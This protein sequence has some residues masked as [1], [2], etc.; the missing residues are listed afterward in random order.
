MKKYVVYTALFGDYDSLIEPDVR[1]SECDFICF[2]DQPNLVSN[3]WKIRVVNRSDIPPNLLNREYKVLP[4]KYLAQYNSSLYIDSNI[5]V[6]S[7]PTP[8]FESLNENEP[9]FIANHP[10]RKCVYE[11]LEACFKSGKITKEV[12]CLIVNK[13]LS[14]GVPENNG[15][16]ENNI[17]LRLHHNKKVIDL[18][19]SW[20]DLIFNFCSRDQISLPYLIWSMRI[21]ISP[22]SV[23]SKKPNRFFYFRPHKYAGDNFNL[24]KRFLF[25]ISMRRSDN[26]FY[27]VVA[28]SFDKI[29]N[30]KSKLK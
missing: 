11:E 6:K 29:Y 18:M 22:L 21:N 17:I 24:I 19:E 5:G 12:K 4:H 27:Y 20:H 26:Y 3:F 13:Y 15:L 9:I 14:E 2:T 1:N 30:F 8:L 7:D 25:N 23:S 28:K 16:T 10:F